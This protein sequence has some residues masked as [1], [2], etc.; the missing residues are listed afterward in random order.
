MKR[1][2]LLLLLGIL[3]VALEVRAQEQDV[4]SASGNTLPDPQSGTPQPNENNPSNSQSPVT[5]VP[6]DSGFEAWVE[7]VQIHGFI[8][9]GYMIST[10]NNYMAR[11]E[12]GTFEFSEAG[13]NFTTEIVESLRLGLQ[14]F[15]YNLG[16]RGNY[17]VA[18]DWAYLD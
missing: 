3:A 9:Q 14:L 11:T 12:E 15:A 2:S 1:L 5:D 10:A 4:Q 17:D 13:V 6:V 8:S 16:D 18:L 7:R